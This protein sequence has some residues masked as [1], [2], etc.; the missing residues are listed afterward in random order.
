MNISNRPISS[1]HRHVPATTGA[2]EKNPAGTFWKVTLS[3]ILN[4][5]GDINFLLLKIP[6]LLL[7][8]VCTKM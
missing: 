5:C 4:F 8:I 6:L 3:G 7:Q 1:R 2:G